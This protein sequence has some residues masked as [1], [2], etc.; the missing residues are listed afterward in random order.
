MDIKNKNFVLEDLFFGDS[1]G[2]T[3]ADYKDNF[4]D[5]YY[6]TSIV[7]KIQNP[8]SFF[9]IGRKGTGKT[10]LSRFICKTESSKDMIF[11]CISF[12][13]FEFIRLREFRQNT[14]PEREYYYIWQWCLLL[15][16][17]KVLIGIEEFSGKFWEYSTL[18]HF[19]EN[20]FGY[21]LNQA[22]VLKKTRELEL[23]GSLKGLIGGKK[24]EKEEISENSYSDYLDSLMSNIVA[25]TQKSGK[26]FTVFCDD[27]DNHFGTDF[28]ASSCESLI[29]AT[30]SLNR[31]FRR[32]GSELK[33]I[34]LLRSDIF[35]GL[36]FS[37]LSKYKADHAVS[38]S[39]RPE[40]KENSPLLD[41]ISH[42]VVKSLNVDYPK[43]LSTVFYHLFPGRIDGRK[44]SSYLI[45]MSMVRPRDIVS[46]LNSAVNLY[47]RYNY[48]GSKTLK[49]SRLTYSR[50]L[51]TDIRSEMVGHATKEDIEK[52]IRLIRNIGRGNFAFQDVV[53]KKKRLVHELGGEAGV[54]KALSFLFKFGLIGNIFHN[55]DAPDIVD[56]YC[57]SYREDILEPDFDAKFNIHIGLRPALRAEALNRNH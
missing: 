52:Y 43:D 6:R 38:L 12:R 50:E 36:N 1:S 4:E 26:Q 35:L 20:A 11:K 32:A 37:E 45:D 8:K 2:E 41:F 44:S 7:E 22:K 39:W 55:P 25:I 54:Q 56:S 15:Y 23:S 49:D 46:M 3:E 28:Y 16:I 31:A 29:H 34:L 42:K 47:P 10:L 30:V 13:D 18:R 24:V 40:D 27:L 21:E 9:V 53:D 57:W 51:L 33:I 14:T 5:Y 48:F 19:I 17:A